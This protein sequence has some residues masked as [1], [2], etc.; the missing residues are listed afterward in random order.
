[1]A[2][3]EAKISSIFWNVFGTCGSR[4]VR[5]TPMASVYSPT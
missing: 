3:L 5:L 4:A 1:M 2:R